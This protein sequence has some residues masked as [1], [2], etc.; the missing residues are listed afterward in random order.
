MQKYSYFPGCSA[1]STGISYTLS[2]NYCTGKL[3]IEF[4]EI[5]DWCC[6]GTSAGRLTSKDL[7]LALPARSLAL[8]EKQYGDLAV[9]APCAGCYSSLKQAAHYVRQSNENRTHVED[10]IEMPYTAAAE[11]V[12][13][14][15]VFA[16]DEVKEALTSALTRRLDGLKVASYYG[17]ALVRPTDVCTFDDAENP[18]SMDDIMALTG[19]VP[20]DWAYKTECC[21]ASNQIAAPKDSRVLIERIFRNAQA[22]GADVIV[23][24]CPLCMLNLDMREKEINQ[25][26]GTAFDIPVY[27][28][29]EL[30][31]ACMGGTVKE[32]GI[33]RHFYPATSLMGRLVTPAAPEADAAAPEAAAPVQPA[34]QKE[35]EA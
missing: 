4:D 2:T 34:T 15:E 31:G 20:V 6:C 30:L 26:R 5:D 12:S 10:L 33:D 24:A 7:G 28:F 3:G 1:E 8:S 25:K 9:V 13:L 27:Y 11:V 32:L 29:T 19:A 17:C 35:V 18:T 14:L 23:T 16:Q 21:G 22:C